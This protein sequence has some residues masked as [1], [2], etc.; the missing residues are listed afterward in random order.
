MT[1]PILCPHCQL[2]KFDCVKFHL[3]FCSAVSW[4][5]W[6]GCIKNSWQ[7]TALSSFISTTAITKEKK[8][9]PWY[10]GYYCPLRWSSLLWAVFKPSKKEVGSFKSICMGKHTQKLENAGLWGSRQKVIQVKPKHS[11]QSNKTKQNLVIFFLC[12]YCHFPKI[13]TLTIFISTIG[14]T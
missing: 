4:Q 9:S 12:F 10:P 11:V 5:L 6:H 13:I 8:T 7:A 14:L 3:I 2:C 1:F